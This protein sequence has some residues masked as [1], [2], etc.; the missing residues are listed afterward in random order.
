MK[1]R[2]WI[3]ILLAAATLLFRGF[4]FYEFFLD[5]TRS[6]SVP[7]LYKIENG[8]LVVD[9]FHGNQAYE[10]GLRK[11]DHILEAYTAGGKGIRIDGL[12]DFGSAL[13]S[14]HKYEPWILLIQR[15]SLELGLILPPHGDLK[16]PPNDL[17]LQLWIGLLLPVLLVISSFYVGFSGLKNRRAFLACLLLLGL[18]SVLSTS[19]NLYAYPPVIREVSWSLHIIQSTLSG[20]LFLLFSL[21]V[22]SDSSIEQRIPWLKKIVRA[23]SLTFLAGTALLQI[24]GAF[25]FELYRNLNSIIPWVQPLSATL[26]LFLFLIGTACVVFHWRTTRFQDDKRRAALLLATT[27]SIIGSYFVLETYSASN[28]TGATVWLAAVATFTG[29]SI[30]LLL[31]YVALERRV[32]GIKR[33]VWRGIQYVLASYGSYII[34]S[35]FI[36]TGLYLTIGAATF[37]LEVSATPGFGWR[38]GAIAALSFGLAMMLPRISRLLTSYLDRKLFSD[39]FHSQRILRDL[40]KAIQRQPIKPEVLI[41]LAISQINRALDVDRVAVFLRGAKIVDASPEDVQEFSIAWI[42]KNG[43]DYQC[44]EIRDR[45]ESEKQRIVSPDELQEYL[46]RFDTS[47]IKTL[48]EK[49]NE[50]Q[51]LETHA[52]GHHDSADAERTILKQLHTTMIVP[53]ITGREL[54][55][56]LSLGEKPAEEPY[57]M[58]EKKLLLA[59]ANQMAIAIE[60]SHQNDRMAEQ[61]KIRRELE[62][63]KQVQLHLFPQRVPL[64]KTLDYVGICKAAREVGGDYY[65]FLEIGPGRL[66]LVVADIS[67]KGISS[68]L[69]MA[70]LQALLRS[71][72]H[73]HGD[74]AELLVWDINRLMHSSTSNGK[75][76]SLFYGFYD[77]TSRLLAYVNAGHL[78]PILYRKDGSCSRLKTGGM[79]V[80]MM[81][82]SAYRQEVIKLEP[83]DIL[84]IFSDGITEAMNLRDQEF[85]E[86]RLVQLLSPL[87]QSSAQSI[88]ETILN[89]IAEHV[90]T[91]PQHDD[92]TLVVLKSI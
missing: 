54:L 79:V 63:A 4:H 50:P 32:F 68:A 66:G 17:F 15:D 83:G 7:F 71:H 28:F 44:C 85:G 52:D 91:A 80:G 35:A 23:V 61:E 11:G 45:S 2:V 59:I 10:A 5:T 87:A 53:M 70:G 1:A 86:E 36:F 42:R 40:A 46:V 56:F 38:L 47:L 33:I 26:N 88:S 64:M 34:A 12:L 58:E 67:G 3:L 24:A 81:P 62:I 82:D 18:S 92:S 8:S 72:A 60:Y 20:Y 51:V 78:P 74:R 37:H 27:L 90:G 29:F 77:D 13:R 65:D 41:D 39:I 22:P 76:A 21:M 69:L 43:F 6:Q 48:R 19:R 73:L 49:I 75:Y 30:P 25:S 84:L 55:G 31:A 16:F 14:S 89:K 57:S 9:S